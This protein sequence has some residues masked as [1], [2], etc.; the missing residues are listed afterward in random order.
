M[1]LRPTR[2]AAHV[3]SRTTSFPA[4]AGSAEPRRRRGERGRRPPRTAGRARRRCWP[5]PPRSGSSAVIRRP[6]AA[7]R[8]R[9]PRRPRARSAVGGSSKADMARAMLAA[10]VSCL[11]AKPQAAPLLGGQL[12]GER[13]QAGTSAGAQPA[14]RIGGRRAVQ[15]H[16]PAVL[17]VRDVRALDPQRRRP[18]DPLGQGARDAEHPGDGDGDRLARTGRRH[19]A[20]GTDQIDCAAAD[21]AHD[22][23]RRQTR[24]GACATAAASGS[25]AIVRVGRAGQ[26]PAGSPRR[27]RRGRPRAARRRC[28]ACR[29][30]RAAAR[31]RCRSTTRSVKKASSTAIP[32]S[33]VGIARSRTATDVSGCRQPQHAWACA[34]E[35][36]TTCR[37]PCSRRS[38]RRRRAAPAARCGG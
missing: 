27:R 11:I 30:H 32:C 10:T 4:S 24:C 15:E 5:V 29:R 38:R 18:L 13:H 1:H 35:Y 21:V 9:A 34:G 7:V 14:D 26:C 33:A 20:V 12:V 3:R 31:P 17:L 8:R 22:G 6:C 28:P 36:R 16:P 25:V 2:A 37:R 19:R 23:V